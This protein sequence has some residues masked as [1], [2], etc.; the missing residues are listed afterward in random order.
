MAHSLYGRNVT[1]LVDLM[2]SCGVMATNKFEAYTGGI[3]NEHHYLTIVSLFPADSIAEQSVQFSPS[4]SH[5]NM[6]LLFILTVTQWTRLIYK[7]ALQN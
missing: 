3:Y 1:R 7:K 6:L 4:H 5:E 2:Y